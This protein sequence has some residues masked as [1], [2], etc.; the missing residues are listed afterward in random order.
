MTSSYQHSTIKHHKSFQKRKRSFISYMKM[1]FRPRSR[2]TRRKNFDLVFRNLSER[3]GLL[4]HCKCRTQ[5]GL[6]MKSKAE[7]EAPSNA[8]K[9]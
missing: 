7:K 5:W 8:C 6:T 1:H 3:E 9:E 4:A 2:V